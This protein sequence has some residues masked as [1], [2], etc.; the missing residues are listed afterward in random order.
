[1]LSKKLTEKMG[2]NIMKNK[3]WPKDNK[4]NRGKARL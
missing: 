3:K 4:G 2:E 1:V